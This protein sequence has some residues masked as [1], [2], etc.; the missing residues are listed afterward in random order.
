MICLMTRDRN[1]KG[2]S[3]VKKKIMARIDDWES[4]KYDSIFKETPRLTKANQKKKQ[5][6][7]TPT[8]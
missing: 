6:N 4:K 7:E 8:Q 5:A 3:N 1:V 2:A